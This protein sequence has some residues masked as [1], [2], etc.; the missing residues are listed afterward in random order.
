MLHSLRTTKNRPKVDGPVNGLLANGVW[1]SEYEQHIR[2]T[3]CARSGFGSRRSGPS[4]SVKVDGEGA[5]VMLRST[6]G[7]IDAAVT[8]R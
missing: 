7:S 6:V 8:T 3:R 5:R 2:W 1:L 4:E